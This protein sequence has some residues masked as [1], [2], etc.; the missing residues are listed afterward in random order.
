[1][2]DYFDLLQKTSER[3]MSV[4][5]KKSLNSKSKSNNKEQ[6]SNSMMYS[7][8]TP[9][10]LTRKKI[11]SGMTIQLASS[12]S[13]QDPKEPYRRSGTK[14]DIYYKDERRALMRY[15]AQWYFN[16]NNRKIW[17]GRAN[18]DKSADISG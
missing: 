10:N 9:K 16:H 18:N 15:K 12:D 2:I 14:E 3:N 7:Q 4:T 1:M 13:L 5:K 17:K 8:H 11:I 6:L